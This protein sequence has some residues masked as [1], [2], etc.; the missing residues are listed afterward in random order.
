MPQNRNAIDE[1]FPF[2]PSFSFVFF[3]KKKLILYPSLSLSPISF[4]FLVFLEVTRPVGPDQGA[5]QG[6]QVAWMVRVGVV[7]TWEL[8]LERQTEPRQQLGLVRPER[9]RLRK[10][11][12]SSRWPKPAGSEVSDTKVHMHNHPMHRKLINWQESL[13]V[14]SHESTSLWGGRQRLEVRGGGGVLECT[15]IS[16]SSPGEST[17]WLCV[18]VCQ[19]VKIHQAA[20]SAFVAF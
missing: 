14:T 5:P 11:P 8:E 6:W 7:G 13:V 17:S 19:R 10:R 3:K 20:H 15:Y 9:L 16:V 12:V 1:L 2:L 18:F 4:V